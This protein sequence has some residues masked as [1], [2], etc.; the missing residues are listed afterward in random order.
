MT[1]NSYE[2]LA[3]QLLKAGLVD[4]RGMPGGWA[5]SRWLPNGCG[6]VASQ[7]AVYELAKPL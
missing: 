6:L 3:G 1:A 5:E 7:A 4:G 2:L